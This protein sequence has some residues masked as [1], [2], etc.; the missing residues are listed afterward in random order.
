VRT[1]PDLRYFSN[2][3]AKRGLVSAITVTSRQG[4]Y[5]DVWGDWAALWVKNA[6]LRR[7]APHEILDIFQKRLLFSENGKR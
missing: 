7:L 3:V 5:F 2:P 6:L 1:E 4:R